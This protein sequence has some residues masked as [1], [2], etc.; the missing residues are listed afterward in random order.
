MLAST[1]DSPAV[2]DQLL[3]TIG[4]IRRA[5]RRQSGR[6]DELSALTGAQLELVRLLRRRPGV[7]V[8][9]AASELRLA[10]NTVSTLVGELSEAGLL[11]RSVDPVDRRVARLDLAPPMRR[12]VERWRDR[13]VDA[14]AAAFERLSAA[15][16][17]RLEAALPC[18]EHL[19]G[20]LEEGVA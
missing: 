18:L 17:R 14:L 12:S 3:A 10:A 15:E 16:R 20:A 5:G 2:A 8:A 11:V 1:L 13:R 19:A 7:S 6:P 4:A 9:D